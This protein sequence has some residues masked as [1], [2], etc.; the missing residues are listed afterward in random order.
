MKFLILTLTL[1][2]TEYN[3]C[4]ASNHSTIKALYTKDSQQ[5]YSQTQI[6]YYNY[7]A[8]KINKERYI[9]NIRANVSSYLE[10]KLSIGWNY[11]YV[12]EFQHAYAKYLD[13]LCDSNNPY[14]LYADDFGT[15]IDNKGILNNT[16][17]DDYWYDNKGN[18][19]SGFD[20]SYLSDKKKKK[21]RTFY[22]NRE[23][24]TYFNEI[25]K[26]IIQEQR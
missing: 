17:A 7:G 8:H 16:D 3:N 10:Y 9:R 24:V 6:V 1:L 19:I 20:Y 22:A 25:A 5:Y 4:F 13:A 2:F 14:R 26:A 23:V 21:Y 11:Y 18:R 12:E 15:I